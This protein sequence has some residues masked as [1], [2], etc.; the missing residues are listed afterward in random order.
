MTRARQR[1]WLAWPDRIMIALVIGLI[2]VYQLTLSPLLGNA[3]RFEPSCSRYMVEALKKYGL[4]LG[5]AKG[6]RRLSRCHPWDPGGYDP[7]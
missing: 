1:S 4:L 3:C 5:I 2:R 7:P 6:L